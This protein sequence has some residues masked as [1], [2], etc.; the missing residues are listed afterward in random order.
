MGSPSCKVGKGNVE[1]EEEV[2]TEAGIGGEGIDVSPIPVK[3]G[4]H[5]NQSRNYHRRHHQQHSYELGLLTVTAP[6]VPRGEKRWPSPPPPTV[7]TCGDG[8][9]ASPLAVEASSPEMNALGGIWDGSSS[10]GNIDS[11]LGGGGMMECRRKATNIARVTPSP[12]TL[13]EAAES[14]EAGGGK[15][16]TVTHREKNLD[17]VEAASPHQ[18]ATR[19]LERPVLAGAPD[20][21]GGGKEVGFLHQQLQQHETGKHGR[22]PRPCKKVKSRLDDG[23]SCLGARPAAGATAVASCARISFTLG[24]RGE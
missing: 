5:H 1:V 10:S 16:G 15:E 24:E 22:N 13:L 11:S 9:D 4:H 18:G 23:V 3:I 7:G 6:V 20:Y 14:V 12:L 8:F 17:F 19:T 2:E 21:C